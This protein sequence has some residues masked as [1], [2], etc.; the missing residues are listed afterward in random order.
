[1]TGLTEKRAEDRETMAK[2]VVELAV[3]CGAKAEIDVRTDRLILV[4]IE[5]GRVKLTLDFDGNSCQPDSHV[6]SWWIGSSHG[7]RFASDFAADVNSF[8]WLKATD[9]A[10]GFDKLCEVLEYRLIK[11]RDGRAF[12]A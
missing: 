3:R 7:P 6:L 2:A 11:I 8:H 5:A 9:F 12:R 10:E 1:M 4:N